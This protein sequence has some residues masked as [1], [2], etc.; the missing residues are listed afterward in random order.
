MIKKKKTIIASKQLK[1]QKNIKIAIM[2]YKVK[3]NK[4]NKDIRYIEKCMST[5]S[6]SFLDIKSLILTTFFRR[7]ILL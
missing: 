3:S 5:I 6:R 7:P 4:T 2:V 1:G